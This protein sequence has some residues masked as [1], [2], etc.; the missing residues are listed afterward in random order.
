MD[1][2]SNY[3]YPKN[4]NDKYKNYSDTEIQYMENKLCETFKSIILINKVDLDDLLYNATIRNLPCIVRLLL[5]LGANPNYLINEE[6][7]STILN[8][9][10][11]YTKIEYLLDL[12]YY[13]SFVEIIE[14]FIKFGYNIFNKK[15]MYLKGNAIQCFQMTINFNLDNYIIEYDDNIKNLKNILILYLISL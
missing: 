14:L 13:L 4:N 1:E 2:L 5:Q 10:F 3:L 6:Y 12:K 11:Y 15:S 7:E 9:V 8:D